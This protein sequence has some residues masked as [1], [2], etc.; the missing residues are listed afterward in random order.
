MFKCLFMYKLEKG[1]HFVLKTLFV[2][3]KIKY[4]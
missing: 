2:Q 1:L 3:S 4:N